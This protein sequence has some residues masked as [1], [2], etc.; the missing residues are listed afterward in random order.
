MA[1]GDDLQPFVDKFFNL[2]GDLART[3][4]IMQ[5]LTSISP[6]R[7]QETESCTTNSVKET[8]SIALER[9]KNANT[10]IKSAVALDLSPCFAP[11][12]GPSTNPPDTTN[13]LKKTSPSGRSNKP[14]STCIIKSNRSNTDIPLLLAFDKEDQPE[15]SRGSTLCA[16]ANLAPSL[17]DECKKLFL[18][19]VEKYLDEVDRKSSLMEYDDQIAGMMYKVK[20]V[21]DWLNVIVKKD[22]NSSKEGERVG[23]DNLEEAEAEAE[24]YVR[25]RNKIYAI[26][27]KHVERTAMAFERLNAFM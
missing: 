21:S 10:W 6:F 5:S 9:K 2:Q 17:Q 22:G 11:L 24:A 13:T 23:C 3:R 20:M 27:L 1:E 26:L 8:L 15:W 12:G 16:A 14:K 4:L 19:Y 25:V 18:S 7:T